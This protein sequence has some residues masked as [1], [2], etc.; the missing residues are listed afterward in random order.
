MVLFALAWVAPSSLA[1]E[2]AATALSALGCVTLGWLLV[3]AVPARWLRWGVYA[4]AALDACLVGANLLQAPSD[5]LSGV[6]PA[7]ELPALQVA[8]F[9]TAR[10]GFGDLFAAAL[11]G[12]LLAANRYRQLEA[13]VLVAAFAFCFDLL[14]FAVDTL[15][16]TVPVAVALAVVSRRNSAQL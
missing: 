6:A 8:N 7:A 5:V 12:C 14:F 1:G 2:A 13:A 15:P 9:G 3:N 4:M 16:A 10:M 11:V